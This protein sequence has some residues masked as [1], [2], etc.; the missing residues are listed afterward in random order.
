MMVS[1]Q[2][3]DQADK[4]CGNQR[5]EDRGRKWEGAAAPQGE[6]CEGGKEEDLEKERCLN[7]FKAMVRRD[8]R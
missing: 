6:R 4:R 7:S 2:K 8:E 3:A 1:L 5:T